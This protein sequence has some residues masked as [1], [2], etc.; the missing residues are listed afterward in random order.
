MVTVSL[1]NLLKESELFIKFFGRQPGECG[2]SE[3]EDGLQRN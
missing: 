3:D 2:D 1:P